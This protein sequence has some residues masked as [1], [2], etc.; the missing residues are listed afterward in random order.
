MDDNEGVDVSDNEEESDRKLQR[1][2]V[3]EEAREQSI[4]T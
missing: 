2:I 1:S 3:S 4:N